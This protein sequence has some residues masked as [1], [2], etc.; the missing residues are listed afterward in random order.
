MLIQFYLFAV[1]KGHISS[2]TELWQ[3]L[4]AGVATLGVVTDTVT[5]AVTGALTG[6]LTGTVTGALTG[7][8][9]VFL[10]SLGSSILIYR[11]NNP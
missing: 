2:T 5:G 4:V 3:V 11:D 9:T 1:S 7:V 8:F 6:A 10:D